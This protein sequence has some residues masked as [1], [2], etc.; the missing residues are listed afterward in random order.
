M[1]FLLIN[2]KKIRSHRLSV[3]TRGFHPRK[4]GSILLGPPKKLI[5]NKEFMYE[6]FGQFIEGKWQSSSSGET[7]DVINPATE[8][9]L[10]KA[11]KANTKDVNAALVSAERGLEVWKNTAPWERAKLSEKYLI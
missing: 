8:E 1:T 5:Y 3:R 7:Y 2:N 11:S 4:R 6:K 9:I 10:G